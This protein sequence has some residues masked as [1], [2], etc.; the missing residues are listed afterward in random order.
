MLPGLPT[1]TR[2]TLTEMISLAGKT[3]MITGAA[4]G[5]GKATAL[6][7]AEA[8]ADIIAV[9]VDGEGL[10]KLTREISEVRIQAMLVDLSNKSEIDRLWDEIEG[11]PD[12]LV[13]NAGVYPF[14]EFTEVEEGF[15]DWVMR[16]NALSVFW[17]SQHMIRR[18]EKRGGVIV[19]VG[20]IEAILPF[21]EDLAHYT[22]SKAAVIALTRSLARDYGRKF[23]VNVVIPGGIY[24][25]GVK[26]VAKKLGIKAMGEAKE[27]LKRLPMGRMGD[28]DEVARVILFLA[29]DMASYVNGA[30][31]PVDGGFLST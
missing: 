20:S 19:N 28:P 9:D 22:M 18:R 4:S 10:Q 31:I 7:F 21:K 5:I 6:R 26:R 24:T 23:R 25:E 30:V 17:M 12:I 3:A 11:A 27:F 15:L 2:P 8:G 13:N 16:V 14:K 1:V 29:S